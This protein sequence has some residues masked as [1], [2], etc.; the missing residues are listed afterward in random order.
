VYPFY[1]DPA[2]VAARQVSTW[3]AQGRVEDA[4]QLTKISSRPT[5]YWLTATS[6]RTTSDVS[7]LVRKAAAAHQMPVLVAYA[8]PHRDCGAYSAGGA[9]SAAEYQA[10]VRAIAAGIGDRPAI[11]ILEPDAIAQSLMTCGNV[12]QERYAL[13]SDAVAVLKGGRQVRVYLDAGCPGWVTDLKALAGALRQSGV[14][15]SDGFALNVAHFVTTPENA[16]YGQRLSDQLGGVHFVIDTGRNGNGPWP[17]GGSANGGPD[18]CNPPGRMLGR[19]PTNQSG[20]PRVDALLWVKQP[21]VS[22]GP[23][24][25]GEPGAGQWWPE[26]ALDLAKRSP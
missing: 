10:W 24:R 5:A 18:W 17:G 16:S 9:G 13:L 4:R 1:V 3:Q 6:A 19:A 8:I 25:P 23:C 2:S 20:L 21:G 7:A 12:A 22:D 11:V 26:Y 14:A 15:R